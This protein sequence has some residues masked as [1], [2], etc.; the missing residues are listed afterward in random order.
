[1][2]QAADNFNKQVEEVNRLIEFD[3]EI[4][5]L[6]T[7]QVSALSKTLRETYGVTSEQKNGLRELN[8]LATIRQNESVGVKFK[9]IFNQAVVLLVSYF[10]AALEDIFRSALAARLLNNPSEKLLKDELK[11]TVSDL[12]KIVEGKTAI[13]IDVWISKKGL[14]F[15]DMQ[16][17]RR[18]FR[19][20][21]DLDPSLEQSA[22]DV[23][24][25][26]QACRHLVVHSGGKINGNFT[27]Q[28][29]NVDTAG[30]GSGFMNKENIELSAAHI[31]LISSSM[32]AILKRYLDSVVAIQNI[33]E[34]VK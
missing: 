30:F 25:V 17:I 2:W 32:R 12:V 3:S 14:S 33:G 1:M 7:M 21:T 22:L 34:G 6:A 20:F 23:V 9:L 26:A 31:K 19:E 11:L 10:A 16:A 15:Q 29:R 18:Q 8:V 24:I 28:L 13:L 27:N 4:L 5:Q